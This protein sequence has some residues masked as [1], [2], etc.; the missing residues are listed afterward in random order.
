MLISCLK[1]FT[2]SYEV[3]ILS[4]KNLIKKEKKKHAKTHSLVTEAT[5]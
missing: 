4:T 5:V 1:V 3:K 2:K